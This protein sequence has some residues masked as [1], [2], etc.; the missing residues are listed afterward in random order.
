MCRSHSSHSDRVKLSVASQHV[1]SSDRL[2]EQQSAGAAATGAA[3]VQ[4]AHARE[5]KAP[6][7]INAALS[8]EC[9]QF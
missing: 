3:A 7:M 5:G 6:I 9:F 4:E 2:R 1:R 8:L